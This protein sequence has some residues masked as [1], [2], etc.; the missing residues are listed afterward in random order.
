[1]IPA[2][3]NM[4]ET[5]KSALSLN[6]LADGYVPLRWTEI[7]KQKTEKAPPAHSESCGVQLL[8]PYTTLCEKIVVIAVISSTL[9][10]ACFDEI[11]TAWPEWEKWHLIH[12]HLKR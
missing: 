8:L 6:T 5:K 2:G 4:F 12:V 3:S 1:M 9:S 10:S 7:W 11:D